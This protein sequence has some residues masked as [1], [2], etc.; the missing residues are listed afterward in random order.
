MKSNSELLRPRWLVIASYPNSEFRI[1]LI[2]TEVERDYNE[3]KG[4]RYLTDFEQYE[5]WDDIGIDKYPHI[6]TPLE[7]WQHLQ[8]NDA[9]EY[10]SDKYGQVYRVLQAELVNGWELHFECLHR[11]NKTHL[12][13][14]ALFQLA[15]E[16]EYNNYNQQ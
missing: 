10:V 14:A 13:P 16:E 1:G 15:T 3:S 11:G 7:W 12:M 8:P 9:P 5:F 2:F 4:R 6:F